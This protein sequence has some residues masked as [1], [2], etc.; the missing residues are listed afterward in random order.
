MN[1]WCRTRSDFNHGWLKNRLI[2]ALSR[3]RKVV[4][5][6]VLD[7]DIWNDLS[8]LLAEW[9][10]RKSEVIG[11]LHNYPEAASLRRMVEN[12]LGGNIDQ[13][14]ANWLADLSHR[15]WSESENSEDRLSKALK[16]IA[17]LD[18]QVSVVQELLPNAQRKQSLNELT[19]ELIKLQI[20]ASYLGNAISA[21]SIYNAC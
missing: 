19:N 7:D 9:H 5:G 4:E 8:I 12:E 21:L 1:T 11:V 20:A 2:V 18:S 17:A 6:M 3:A 15:R 13:E 16:A 10:V 14:L